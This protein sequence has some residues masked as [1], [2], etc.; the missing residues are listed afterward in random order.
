[1]KKHM[2]KSRNSLKTEKQ[3]DRWT[4]WTAPKC[5]LICLLPRPFWGLNTFMLIGEETDTGQEEPKNKDEYNVKRSGSNI[6][7][8]M[9]AAG[10]TLCLILLD[11]G[12]SF[13]VDLFDTI[14][15]LQSRGRRMAQIV[16]S[17]AHPTPMQVQP[18]LWT[19]HSLATFVV[20]PS[21]AFKLF[22]SEDAKPTKQ[23]LLL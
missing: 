3:L 18:A 10:N 20:L 8:F 4:C 9:N 22:T 15:Y 1:M 19:W 6:M 7:K 17:P 13:R 21:R 16:P 12:L 2:L 14:C 23:L 11:C 5:L